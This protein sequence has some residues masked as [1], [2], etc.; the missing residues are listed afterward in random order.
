[1]HS[2]FIGI[3]RSSRTHFGESGAVAGAGAELRRG[4]RSELERQSRAGQRR[5]AQTAGRPQ[6]GCSG[7][8]GLDEGAG[9]TGSTVLP[10]ADMVAVT[11]GTV[12]DSEVTL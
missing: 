7:V 8:G 4:T 11:E 10:S 12:L 3:L 1:M 5:Q 9:S 2:V 6:G